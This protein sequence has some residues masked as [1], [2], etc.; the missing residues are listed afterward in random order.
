MTGKQRTEH[1]RHAIAASCFAR[2]EAIAYG[3]DAVTDLQHFCMA[4]GLDYWRC[5]RMAA[6]HFDA[7]RE[8]GAS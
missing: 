6:L 8:G 2:G 5:A 7:E 4:R 1:A 3:E